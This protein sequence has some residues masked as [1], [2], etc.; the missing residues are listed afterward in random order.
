M[1]TTIRLDDALLTDA[2]EVAARSGKTLAEVVEDALRESLARRR[3]NRSPRRKIRL[4]TV[5]GKGVR[6]GIDIDDSAGLLD[7]MEVNDG[8]A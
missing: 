8:P 3:S 1:R 6:R 4:P 2:K 7:A 5:K